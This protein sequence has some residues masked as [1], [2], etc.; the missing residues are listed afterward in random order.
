MQDEAVVGCTIDGI[1]GSGGGTF[2]AGGVPVLVVLIVE[3]SEAVVEC[4][5][6]RGEA[7]FEGGEVTNLGMMG[8]MAASDT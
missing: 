8:R 1:F 2:V 5:E 7:G 6:G 4:N 3:G